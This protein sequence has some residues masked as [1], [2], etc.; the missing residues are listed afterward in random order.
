MEVLNSPQGSR[1]ETGKGSCT[2]FRV[3]I[4]SYC[5]ILSTTTSSNISLMASLVLL[6][7]RFNSLTRNSARCRT[8]VD[9]FYASLYKR[10]STRSCIRTFIKLV[11]QGSQRAAF[12][13]SELNLRDN[14]T[15]EAIKDLLL[16]IVVDNMMQYNNID[17]LADLVKG[18]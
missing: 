5:L 4:L 1:T 8:L 17:T 7:R 15:R 9:K 3:F 2:V 18:I 13:A 14:K 12:F 11:H 16:L 6:P 10:S